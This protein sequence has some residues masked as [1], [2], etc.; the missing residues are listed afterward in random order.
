MTLLNVPGVTLVPAPSEAKTDKRG[1]RTT[2]T[3][4]LDMNTA[5]RLLALGSTK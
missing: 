4:A 3:V 2:P 1:R 5:I